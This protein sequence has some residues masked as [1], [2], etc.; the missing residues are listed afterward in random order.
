M[1][2]E[3]DLGNTRAKWRILNS[4]ADIIARGVDDISVWLDGDF[5]TIWSADIRRVRIASVLSLETET[6]LVSKI[7]SA[8]SLIPEVARSSL[9]CVGV[10]NAYAAPERLGVDRWL[11]LIAAYKKTESAVMVVDVGTALKVDV[12]DEAGRH[13]G[14]YIIP[15]AV[16][17]EC[18]LFE[19][20]DRVRFESGARLESVAFGADTRSCVQGGITAA[21]MGAVLVAVEQC[22]SLMGVAPLICV[23]GG[24]GLQIRDCLEA[25]GIKDI[26]CE[27]DLVLDGLRWALP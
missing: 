11:A 13:L 16:L 10:T 1:I 15:G 7:R 3:L 14:G 23:T 12:A 6:R 19:G 17:M 2:L 26:C 5:P 4:S 27:S 21:L 20:T 24:L 22:R 8:L 18:A 9:H 25:A